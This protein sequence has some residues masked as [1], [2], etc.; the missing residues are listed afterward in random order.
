MF[1]CIL[2]LV[3]ILYETSYD[4][5]HKDH[6]RI[7]RLAVDAKVSNEFFEAAA[8]SGPMGP[9]LLA[10]Y[11]EEVELFTR[12]Q[13]T[14]KD[15]LVSVD[16]KAFYEEGFYYADS[17]F[18]EMFSFKL[19][20]G[21]PAT[22]LDEPFSL[23]IDQ[24]LADKYFEGTNALGQMVR[25]N[26]KHTYKIT[27]I[28]ENCNGNSHFQ[29]RM[30]ASFNTLYEISDREF[31]ENW[32][33]LFLG[34]YIKLRPGVDYRQMN[35]K[36]TEFIQNHMADRLEVNVVFMPYL[37][38]VTS[39]HLH[40]HLI[41]E[42]GENSDIVYI[43]IFGSVALLVMI[44]ACINFMNLATARSMKRAKEIGL[45]KVIGAD[46]RLL[47]RQFIGESIFMSAISLLIAI[48]LVELFI[49]IFSGLTGIDP[50]FSLISKW[51]TTPALLLMVLVVGSLAGSYPA[52]Y[53]SSIK[54]AH[55]LKGG[56]NRISGK[57]SFRN[58]LVLV[59]FS[60][61]IILLISTGIIYRQMQYVDVKRLGFEKEHCIV[62]PLRSSDLRQKSEVIKAELLNLPEVKSVTQSSALPG[63]NMDGNGFFPEGIE[64]SNPWIINTIHISYDYVETL[65]LNL[66]EGRSHSKSFST[67][68][69]AILINE[70]LMKKLGWK[71]AVGKKIYSEWG[72]DS[73]AYRIIGVVEDFHFESLHSEVSPSIMM[74]DFPYAY[75]MLVRLEPGNI[76]KSIENLKNEWDRVEKTHPF[77]Y[78][79][80]DQE[81]DQMYRSEN[82]M[83]RLFLIFTIIAIFIAC[84][85]LFG[86]AS[87]VAEQKTKEIGIR[88]AVGASTGHLVS[89][90]TRQFLKWV[91]IA[92]I[93]GWPLAYIMMENWLQRFAYRIELSESWYLFIF[94]TIISLLIAFVTISYQSI[95]AATANPL[96]ALR[97][98]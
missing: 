52:F 21:D 72:V 76:R 3:Y 8:S 83:T 58:I 31:Y 27:G 47:I 75:N 30:L 1:V 80:L 64:E 65:G 13:K 66:I 12:I 4:R 63:S 54:P 46:R 40:S 20:K 69:S 84:L 70:S 92:N 53:L 79:F 37:Q 32:G 81:V 85:G 91:L 38:P 78:F 10:D 23:V 33:A 18:F 41:G 77:S 45:R 93:I 42:I 11:P 9:A 94:S 96:I 67:D 14:P 56:K 61:S 82:N 26:G 39:I 2:I 19:L 59:Q 22:A 50:G 48:V 51:Y 28:V 36:F 24:S 73:T 5:F 6:E 44:I 49:D 86:L 88:K 89:G 57:S 34:T 60:I 29:F 87:F 16:Q 74:I 55:A 97:Y 95:R 25:L 7:F 68:E 90:L 17:T 71:S 15:L 43:Y 98:E 35:E 62:I